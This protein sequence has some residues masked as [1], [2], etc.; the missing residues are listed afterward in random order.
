MVM[1]LLSF[2]E[3]RGLLSGCLASAGGWRVVALGESVIL[4]SPWAGEWADLSRPAEVARLLSTDGDPAA[5]GACVAQLLGGLVSEWRAECLSAKCM[6]E[7]L[8]ERRSERSA[9]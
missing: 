9:E 4:E 6:S 5:A 8:T 1:E 7:W 2:E 3:S